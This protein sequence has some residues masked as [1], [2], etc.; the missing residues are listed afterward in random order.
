MTN[1]PKQK[2]AY[3]ME[4]SENTKCKEKTLSFHH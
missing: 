1:F 2:D 3:E 4:I